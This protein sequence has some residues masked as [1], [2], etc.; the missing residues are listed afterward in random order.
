M[1]DT[2]VNKI[3][4]EFMHDIFVTKDPTHNFRDGHKLCIPNFNTIQYG[5][6]TF[7]YYGDHLWNLL[8]NQFK[9]YIDFSMFKKLIK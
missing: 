3:N 7:S 2:A 1:Y 6:I 8:P 4:P 5:K 9:N